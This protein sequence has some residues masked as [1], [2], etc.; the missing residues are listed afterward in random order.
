MASFN[1]LHRS[2][3]RRRSGFEPEAT[4]V[5]SAARRG[6]LGLFFQ[7]IVSLADG[8]LAGFEGL[9]RW[10]HR[11]RG[12][13]PAAEFIDL[14]ERTGV[15]RELTGQ[16]IDE[17]C[18]LAARLHVRRDGRPA[19]VA[20]NLPAGEL[21]NTELPDLFAAASA[22]AGAP[23]ASVVIE[24]TETSPL[25]DFATSVETLNR[26]RHLGVGIALDDFGTAYSPLILARHL[27][28]T[29]LKIDRA[30]V[31]DIVDSPI[32]RAIAESV[33]GLARA[34]G[35]TSVAEGVETPQQARALGELGCDLAQGYL[36]SPAVPLD[37]I[38]RA[39][40][41]IEVRSRRATRPTA[42]RTRAIA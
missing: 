4:E 9:L 30:F 13:V 24:I 25:V 21:T 10:T 6:E 35:A 12:I 28:V 16:L 8:R 41:K 37:G 33:I 31:A 32:D 18:E 42:A 29:E 36:W 15:L 27:P 17:T 22:R 1:D 23:P 40:A 34:L 38:D 14:A 26:L 5:I 7:P 39:V 11:R 19:F 2:P 3:L 20:L